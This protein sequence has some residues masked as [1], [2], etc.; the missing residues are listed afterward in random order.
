M[1]AKLIA[2]ARWSRILV[3][4]ICHYLGAENRFMDTLAEEFRAEPTADRLER[5]TFFRSDAMIDEYRAALLRVQAG[6]YGRCI[7]CGGAIDVEHLTAL[8]HA[9]LC[10]A[11][12]ER[13]SR[14]APDPG[15]GAEETID[16]WAED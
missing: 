12:E 15:D 7:S 5:L 1:S 9:R 3:D 6:T 8:P 2:G 13:Y 16:Q 10:Q 4:R 11:C 14:G